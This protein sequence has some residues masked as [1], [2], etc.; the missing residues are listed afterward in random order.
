LVV[1]Y[2]IGE[3]VEKIVMKSLLFALICF[4]S[5]PSAFSQ[6]NNTKEG[7]DN[8][9]EQSKAAG[10]MRYLTPGTVFSIIDKDA[11]RLVHDRYDSSRE[12]ALFE[13]VEVDAVG[14]DEDD[15]KRENEKIAQF[16]VMESK[17]EGY[18]E[19]GYITFKELASEK[20][21]N[22]AVSRM[23]DKIRFLWSSDSN[24]KA[25]QWFFEGDYLDQVQV[26]SDNDTYLCKGE[27]FKDEPYYIS[28]KAKLAMLGPKS[29]AGTFKIEL[30][31][32]PG[33]DTYKKD[34]PDTKQTVTLTLEQRVKRLEDKIEELEKEIEEVQP[35]L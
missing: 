20:K 8:V 35:D 6:E 9:G 32:G 1:F 17:Y 24:R 18:K 15:N 23:G 22:Y 28:K 2:N 30:I 4:L 14:M 11:Y 29:A 7:T 16:Q 21:G 13:P 3:V 5:T 10:V 12:W 31:R 25:M 27:D 26:K 33:F 34:F 19:R